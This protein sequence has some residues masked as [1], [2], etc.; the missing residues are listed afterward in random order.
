MAYEENEFLHEDT[1]TLTLD[2]NSE[3]E[4]AIIG[5]IFTAG[6]REYIALLPMSGPDSEEGQVYLYRYTET[7]GEPNLENIVEDEEF[8]LA[9]DAFDEM[10]DGMEYDELVEEDFEDDSEEE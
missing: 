8:E 1:V 5:D 6:G 10:L 7:D 2:D 4:C 3:L 9:S